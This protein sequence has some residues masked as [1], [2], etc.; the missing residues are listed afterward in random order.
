MSNRFTEDYYL[1]G[2]TTGLSNYENYR[3]LPELTIPMAINLA[4]RLGMT[5]GDSALDVGC[6]RGY[7]VKALKQIGIQAW[8]YDISEWAIANCDPDV[9]RWVSNKMWNCNYDFVYS[10]NTL[11]HVQEDEL[12]E[13]L[14]KMCAMARA[15]V[16]ILV[17]LAYANGKFIHPK[18]ELD[19]THILRWTFDVWMRA[20]S[21]VS[22]DFTVSGSYFYP[23]LKPAAEES[24]TG[25]G[26]F[27]MERSN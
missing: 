5:F 2:R 12:P 9:K 27:I 10:L 18:E 19:E 6:A 15:K 25:Y 22:T 13:L 1:C 21:G 4:R 26:F 16:F 23:G 3:W 11:E 7:A 14:R 24:P 8:G 17:P 20:L